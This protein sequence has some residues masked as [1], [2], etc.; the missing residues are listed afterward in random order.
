MNRTVRPLL[1][2][3]VSLFVFCSDPNSGKLVISG[4]EGLETVAVMET[5]EGTIVVSF[6]PEQA[7]K[8]AENF[9]RLCDSGFYDGTYFHRVGA[10]F[11]IQGGDPN[12]KDDD[13]S[14]DGTGG[15]GSLGAGTTL[16]PEFN[17][18]HH[19]RGIV[20]MS[21][22]SDPASAGSQFFILLTDDASLDGR[23]TAFGKVVEGLEVVEAIAEQ[24]GEPYRVE[25]GVKPAEV[26]HVIVCWVEQRPTP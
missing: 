18:I 21:H 25:G 10:G 3:L 23:Y 7:P 26:Q 4:S 5:S 17:D 15:H 24:P 12:T 19:T 11:M 6:F 16:E 14:N 2:F 9:A 22:T 1:L 20:S 8:H 13:P